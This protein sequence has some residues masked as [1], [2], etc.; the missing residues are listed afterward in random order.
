M[1]GPSVFSSRASVPAQNR[2]DL[3]T[4]LNMRPGVHSLVQDS[5]RLVVVLSATE[6][7]SLELQAANLLAYL[8]SRPEFF[9]RDRLKS[10]ALTL[11]RRSLFS[12]RLAVPCSTQLELMEALG[13]AQI[14]PQRSTTAPRIAYIF[15]GQGAQWHAMGRELVETYPVFSST[16]RVAEDCLKALGA[17]WSLSDELSKDAAASL[18]GQ[19]HISQPACTAIQIALV[20]LFASWDILPVAVAGH[21]SGEIAAA[22]AA[23]ALPIGICM[24][25]A[26]H[27][28]MCVVNLS[29]QFSYLNGSMLALGVHEAE[30]RTLIEQSQGKGCA[31]IACVNSPKSVTISGDETKLVGLKTL[32]DEKKIFNRFLH[33]GV[34]YH[35]P[36]MQ[37][38]ANDYRDHLATISPNTQSSKISFYSSLKGRLVEHSDL[39]TS[40]WV[41]NLTSPVLFSNAMY[42]LCSLN[43]APEIQIDTLIELGPHSALRGPIRQILLELPERISRPSYLSALIRDESAVTTTLQ[44]AS[45]LLM[46]GLPLDLAAVNFSGESSKPSLITDLPSYSWTHD[47]R[48]WAESRVAR[49]YRLK[50]GRRNELIGNL[51]GEV[52]GDE[53][54]WRI[55]VNSDSM[56]WVRDHKV[57]SQILFPVAGYLILAMEA[58]A[59][60]A[61]S[62]SKKPDRFCLRE[63]VVDRALVLS[64]STDIEMSISLRPHYGSAR[65]SSASW[66][67]FSIASW[68]D[69]QGWNEHCK[70]LVVA[71]SNEKL[72]PPCDMYLSP[73]EGEY[74]RTLA[75]I[76]AACTGH[77]DA[78]KV[79]EILRQAGFDYGSL[80]RGLKNIRT[81]HGKHSFGEVYSADTASSMPYGYEGEMLMHPATLDACIHSIWPII[82][83]MNTD[84]LATY[85]PTY[86]KTVSMSPKIRK[87]SGGMNRVYATLQSGQS[88]SKTVTLNAY[89]VDPDLAESSFVFEIEGLVMTR[90]SDEASDMRDRSIAYRT[91]WTP[92]VSLLAPEQY[93]RL[94]GPDEMTEKQKQHIRLQ[95]EASYYYIENCLTAIPENHYEAMPE[96]HRRLYNWM[97][98]QS[99]LAKQGQSLLQD[100]TWSVAD[101]SIR[102]KILAQAAFLNTEGA[103]LAKLGAH[104]PRIL[105]G[106]VDPLSE[107]VQDDLLGEYYRSADAC[108]SGCNDAL[109]NAVKLLTH[110][111]PHLTIFEIG[112]G[113]GTI[114]TPLVEALVSSGKTVPFKN[115]CFTDISNGFL[116]KGR[117]K[118][119][120]LGGLMS[121]RQ[122]DAARDPSEQGF[123]G[124]TYDVVVAHLVLHAT[125]RMET[126]MQNVRRLLRPGGHL[127]LV[128]NTVKT[129]RLF[130]FGT[131]PGWWLGTRLV[132][133]SI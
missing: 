64:E 23:K 88:A 25:I 39:D 77:M 115:Y 83:Q 57:Q 85:V 37:L 71:Q 98:G 59:K 101:K 96:H 118:F 76:E 78:E 68:T 104:L 125:K 123:M 95:E 7:A 127:L 106:E 44:M 65:T 91:S 6:K 116:E 12:W 60:K 114:A 50:H 17:D 90:I 62:A 40:Y 36:H 21:S 109:V 126:T 47:E 105:L 124:Q 19:P 53:Q 132:S 27:R 133:L 3:S 108:V 14:T 72:R 119:A 51:A 70:G 73:G 52:S 18:I 75:D 22:Y 107:M 20:D 120:F 112:G 8:R 55:I 61:I 131:L 15:T 117:S 100:H 69:D 13:N 38:V 43:S 82:I 86:M 48:Y 94:L 42:N 129:K 4:S 35:S 10:L 113:T 34:A 84:H 16:I 45:T 46:A 49:G 28:G 93:Q 41:D 87:E 2:P 97:K 111:N 92:P 103:F 5:R 30:A 1:Q 121:F 26:Y 81:D 33:T 66:N 67:E 110:E 80:F 11:Q 32:A 122:F 102:E 79:Y 31:I 74:K 58:T 89:V 29:R 63:V 99:Y 130:P 9:Y 24:S 128:E 54:R 56:P